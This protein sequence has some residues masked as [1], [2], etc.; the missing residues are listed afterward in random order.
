MPESKPTVFL[1][2]ISGYIF[3]AYYA[4]R[5][6]LTAPDGTPTN[7]VY[8]FTTMLMKLIEDENPEYLVPVFDV[9]RQTFRNELYPDYKAN[10]DET[11]TDLIPQFDLIRQVV[12]AYDLPPVEMQ[13]FEADDLIGTL[14]A[15]LSKAGHPVAI[16]TSDKDLMQLV[17]DEVWLIDTWK[18]KVIH[19]AEV[20]ERF[21][22]GPDKVIEVLGL[23]GDTSDNVPGV[24]GV[25]EKTAKALVQQFGDLE[26]VL[27]N[28][29]Q[30][31]GKK[32][33]EKLIDNA[34]LAR[35]S[36]ELVT[37][38][39]DVP[40]EFKLEDF[41]VNGWNTEK[42]AELFTALGFTSLLKQIQ[43]PPVKT[44]IDREAYTLVDDE[45]KLLAMIDELKSAGQAAF[46]TETR[47]I[48]PLEEDPLV[49]MSFCHRAGE[50]FYLPLAHDLTAGRQ[51]AK[52][53]SLELLQPLFSDETFHWIMQNAKFDLQ[54]L[55]SE[56][57]SIAGRVDDTMLLSYTHNP[58][59]RRHGL[60]ALALQHLGHKMISYEEVA[61][62][63]KKQ[64]G[65]WQV[66]LKTA[67]QY[68]AEDADVTLR[69]YDIL[70][71][72]MESAGMMAFY[73]EFERPL[74]EVL[75]RME[76]R[77]IRV[78]KDALQ[79]LTE[80][81]ER[82]IAAL[83]LEI[84]ELAGKSFNVAS[85]QQLG[86]VLFEELELPRGRKTKK[87]YSTDSKVLEKLS[88]KHPL[89][90]KV[91]DYRQMAKLR[92]TYTDALL[93]LIHPRS[94]R[95]HSSFNQTVALTG[96]LSSSDPNMQNIPI[97]TEAGRMIRQAFIP[98]DGY[99]L[100]SADYSQVELRI[101]A[102]LSE[103]PI[104][105]DS[106]LNDEDIHQRTAAEVFDTMAAFV[107]KEMRRR[108]KA[109][110]YGIVYGQTAFGLSESLG[111]RRGEAAGII[112]NYFARYSGV[113][114]YIDEQQ[115]LARKR[116][117]VETLFG[118]KIQL[119]DIDSP[120]VNMR[121]YAERVAINAPIQGTAA[122]IIKR[123]MIALEDEIHR[124]D[125]KSCMLLQ[126]HDE[127]VF[128]VQE[129]ELEE[130]QELV[131]EKMEGAAELRVPLKVDV[132]SGKNWDEAH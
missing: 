95:I 21:G 87:S 53:R 76:R 89:P 2:D 17:T 19:A 110:N 6:N 49:G 130:L 69:L 36:R 68:A 16:V 26:S 72:L 27:A 106:F 56:G 96:R 115:E 18:E 55:A 30:V 98:A 81:F 46:D 22:V 31:S 7:A 1:V 52:A 114:R 58:A 75:R 116:K 57:L 82:M 80:A 71:D 131:V 101:L 93:R 5:G 43:D 9:S 24:P 132:G 25:G 47:S 13:G 51:L 60:D 20:I 91:L 41:Q 33:K 104:L 100:L 97:R 90:G 67:C 63:G 77:G 54:V 83:E 79:A 111:I 121:K 126:V 37:I 85:T 3:R 105:I 59:G 44:I 113:K 103:D 86:Q 88:A 10:R 12:S 118:R 8:G 45:T 99:L 129:D 35:L 66:D 34:D 128:E 40:L 94:G 28:I 70:S 107:D 4:I 125:L 29:D 120:N 124:R 39:C 42:A 23:A 73:E 61:G 38:K 15:R 109:V 78:D 74:I 92:S 122:D 123:A 11:P 48:D 127:L 65:F 108:A 62:K 64:I 84:F 50:A 117:L 112:D 102:H 119:L 32:R 14:A